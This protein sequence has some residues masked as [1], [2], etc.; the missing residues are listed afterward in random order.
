MKT[1][2]ICIGIIVGVAIALFLLPSA[3]VSQGEL[4]DSKVGVIFDSWQE[5]N[6]TDGKAWAFIRIHAAPTNTLSGIQDEYYGDRVVLDIDNNNH[7]Q[8]IISAVQNRENAKGRNV[9][10][11][12]LFPCGSAVSCQIYP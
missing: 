4:I 12:K 6:Y 10:L 11:I 5:D 2:H 1:K 3:V 9:T 8:R 7:K